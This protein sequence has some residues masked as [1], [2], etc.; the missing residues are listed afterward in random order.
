[1][2]TEDTRED[3][4][5]SNSGE[6]IKDE[7]NEMV[8]DTECTADC[9][10]LMRDKPN[11]PTEKTVLAKTKRYQG[12]GKGRQARDVCNIVGLKNTYGFRCVQRGINCF[13][14]FVLKQFNSIY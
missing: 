5:C 1:M 8:S 7:T 10:H 9:C 4:I 3:I 2:S 12:S 11:Q 14:L 13:V 6:E